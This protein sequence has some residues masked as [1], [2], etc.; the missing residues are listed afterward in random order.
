MKARLEP[1]VLLLSLVMLVSAFSGCGKNKASDDPLQTNT[2]PLDTV[3]AYVPEYID[4]PEEISYIIDVCFYEDRLYMAAS[5]EAEAAADPGAENPE[6]FAIYQM[7]IDDSEITRLEGYNAPALPDGSQGYMYPAAMSIDPEGNLWV[8]EYEIASPVYYLRRLDVKGAELLRADISYIAE[9][10]ENIHI[11]DMQADGNGNI[12]LSDLYSGVYVFNDKGI[13]SFDAASSG[14][15]YNLLRLSDG[16]VA[17]YILDIP[18]SYLKTLDPKAKNWGTEIPISYSTG[19]FSGSGVYDYYYNDGSSLY[20]Y[21]SANRES[22]EILNWL[23]C[24][25]DGSGITSL[26]AMPNGTIAC[27]SNSFDEEKPSSELVILEIKD[28]AT[29]AKTVLK[30]ACFR[31]DDYIQGAVRKYN[32]ESKLYKIEVVDYS[33]YNTDD[34]MTAGYLKL[35][36]EIIS[37]NIPDIICV[38]RQLPV[39]KYIALGL[40][41]NLSTYL[42]KDSTLGGRDAYIPEILAALETEG[43]LYRIAPGFSISTVIGSSNVLGDRDSWTHDDVAELLRQYPEGTQLTPDTTAYDVLS[44]LSIGMDEYINWQTGECSFNSESFINLL[45]LASCFPVSAPAGGDHASQLRDG[46][47]LVIAND[48]RSFLDFQIYRALFQ[49]DISCVGFP[50][51]SGGGSCFMVRKGLSITSKCEHKEAAWEFIA[52]VISEEYQVE[53]A[54]HELPTNKAAFEIYADKAMQSNTYIN[55]E[56]EVAEYPAG[57]GS[58]GDFVVDLYAATKE[59]VDLVLDLIAGTKKLAEQDLTV[60]RIVQ[61]EAFAYFSDQCSASDA[62]SIIQSRVNTYINEQR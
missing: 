44:L 2:E 39:S 10:R 25:I 19:V 5:L 50:T 62:A 34:D 23:D 40:L 22:V 12:Y 45:E 27:F 35:D 59:D 29:D 41:E 58:L 57:M 15:I 55:E 28:V 1:S 20:G 53:G 13:K 24:D 56:G 47:A 17:A 31:L 42:D 14:T 60:L 18:D 51:V 38:N 11:N 9:G 21:S 4:L 43:A 37:G 7:N 33:Q 32:N 61:E 6:Y 36:T 49:S 8:F 52:L 54:L 16:T 48:I 46:R 3:L 30:L 26:A